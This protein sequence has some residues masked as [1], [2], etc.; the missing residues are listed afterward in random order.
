SGLKPKAVFPVDLFGMPA[1]Y[2]DIGTIADTAGL[3]VLADAAQSFGASY[4]GPAGGRLA[5]AAA[6]NLFPAKPLGCYRGGR[7]RVTGDTEAAEI[8][9]S[10]RVHGQGKHKYDNVRLGL[11]GRL[12]SIQAAVLIEK[13]KIFPDEIAARNRVAQRYDS[14]LGNLA[15]VPRLPDDRTSVWAQYTIRLPSGTRDRLSAE[16][17]AQGIPPVVYYP[18]PLHHQEAFGLYPVVDG[19]VPVSE[20]LSD[21]VLSLPMHAYLDEPTQDR[22]IEALQRALAH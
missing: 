12:D 11:T 2:D 16:L 5:P 15:V 9:E 8:I 3:F 21:E 6:T 22:I 1:D 19:G 14:S 4:R 17:A 7:A 10:L 13:L 18:K 20:R